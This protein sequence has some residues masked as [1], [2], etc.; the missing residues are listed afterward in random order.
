MVI[1]SHSMEWSDG[2]V[3][4]WRWIQIVIQWSFGSHSIDISSHSDGGGVYFYK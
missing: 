2:V 3:E 4:C 1:Y